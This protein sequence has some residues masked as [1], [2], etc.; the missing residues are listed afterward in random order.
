MSH[1]PDDSS[2]NPYRP[3]ARGVRDLGHDAQLLRDLA[4]INAETVARLG[5]LPPGGCPCSRSASRTC[6]TSH[7][8]PPP[9]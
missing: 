6:R 2:D 7:H 9:W 4:I 8:L 5:P 1:D 3:R